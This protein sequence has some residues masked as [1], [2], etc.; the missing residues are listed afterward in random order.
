[1]DTEKISYFVFLDLIINEI[2]RIIKNNAVP[3][4][5]KK[6]V[7]GSGKKNKT[8]NPVKITIGINV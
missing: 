1:M 5:D 4:Y 3:K 7:S 2:M 6:L 8:T